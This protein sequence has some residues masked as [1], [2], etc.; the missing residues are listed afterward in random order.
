M[1]S[2]NKVIASFNEAVNDKIQQQLQNRKVTIT[3]VKQNTKN[4]DSEAEINYTLTL[5]SSQKEQHIE[6]FDLLTATH[7]LTYENM[8]E[9]LSRPDDVI[10][11]FQEEIQIEMNGTF[12][13]EYMDIENYY[14]TVSDNAYKKYANQSLMYYQFELM[15]LSNL[16][17]VFEQQLRKWLYQELIN[18]YYKIASA[19]TDEDHEEI[20][21][22]FY[23]DFRKL[24]NLFTELGLTFTT[25][26]LGEEEI[27]VDTDIWQTIRECNLLSNT[28]KHG[29]GYS[30]KQLYNIR[31]EYF[32]KVEWVTSTRLMDLYRTTNLERVLNV[33]KIEFKKYSDA[34]KDFWLN[35]KDY[36]QGRIKKSKIP[37]L[38]ADL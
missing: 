21:G 4:N 17:Q 3:L 19:L 11:K 6:I 16:Y 22:K 32:E 7:D 10:K 38:I 30:A 18:G 20:Y 35:M 5:G 15:S 36:Q 31:P 12:D 9:S 8:Y 29:S 34:M 1:L 27:I 2:V 23:G 26:Y 33:E 24:T 37:F 14:D 25:N 13:P 28:Y